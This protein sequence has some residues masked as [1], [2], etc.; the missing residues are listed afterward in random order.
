MMLVYTHCRVYTHNVYDEGELLLLLHVYMMFV[1]Y[2]HTHSRVY[3][4]LVNYRGLHALVAEAIFTFMSRKPS[5]FP[6]APF[7]SKTD[8][9][10][11]DPWRRA[12]VY[13][14]QLRTM[15]GYPAQKMWS[16]FTVEDYKFNVRAFKRWLKRDKEIMSKSESYQKLPETYVCVIKRKHLS[17]PKAISSCQSSDS[18]VKRRCVVGDDTTDEED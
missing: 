18:P 17:R 12:M 14:F 10:S 2:I 11:C 15:L 3:T 13:V 16:K 9:W 6:G 5:P 7:N 4:Q 8:F 1:A